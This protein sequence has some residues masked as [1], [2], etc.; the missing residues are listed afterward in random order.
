M[1]A[2]LAEQGRAAW[3]PLLFQAPWLF[4]ISSCSSRGCVEQGGYLVCVWQSL[5]NE[6]D[7]S[8]IT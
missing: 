8:L 1:P 5:R 2:P 4:N 6:A 3:L 7:S